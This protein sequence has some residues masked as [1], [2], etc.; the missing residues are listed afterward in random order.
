MALWNAKDCG[1]WRNALA[2]YPALIL[3]HEVTQLP[4][5]DAWYRNELP[6]MLAARAKPYVTKKE[7]LEI[8]RWKMKRGVWPASSQTRNFSVVS[9]SSGTVWLASS[10]SMGCG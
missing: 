3:A 4:E 8:L 6:G 2:Q 7:M 1:A 5:I 10:G 9:L